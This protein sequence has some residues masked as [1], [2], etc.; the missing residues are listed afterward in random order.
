MSFQFFYGIEGAYRDITFACCVYFLRNFSICIP[1]D[2]YARIQKIGDHI[3]PNIP[4]S[5]RKFFL[6][7]S[8]E[9]VQIPWGIQMEFTFEH[10]K[11]VLL[12]NNNYSLRNMLGSSY[13]LQKIHDF[14]RLLIGSMKDELPEQE[15]ALEFIRP[16]DHVVELGSNIG[17]N[18]I[19][20]SCILTDPSKQLV[21][22]ECNPD[23]IDILRFHR[24]I[25]GLEFQIINSALSKRPLYI[26]DWETT[27]ERNINSSD[28]WK[29][30]K[31]MD[32]KTMED[33]YPEFHPTVLVAD[34]EGA[35][36]PIFK[37]DSEEILKNLRCVIMENDY[38]DIDQYIYVQTQL[39]KHNF[40]CHKTIGGGWGP[41]ANF[42][43]QVWIRKL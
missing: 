4:L 11:N 15:L 7:Y 43:Y 14:T 39:V 1:A 2:F 36:Y 10:L 18:T 21:T 19:V 27:T 32:W 17:R 24:D 5:H 42:F 37:D 29:E 3:P 28:E 9:I 30:I 34:C 12:D 20:L 38:H 41:C 25:N 13:D 6:K 31:T 23:F 8:Q 33:T 16:D 35:L 22:F 40:L 26:R